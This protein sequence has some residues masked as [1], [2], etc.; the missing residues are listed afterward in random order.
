MDSFVDYMWYLLLSPWKR[1]KKAVN[2]WYIFCKVFGGMLD[3]GMMVL[4][5]ARDET[6][7][8]TCCDE[9]LDI[10]GMEHGLSRYSGEKED[11]FR[12][13]IAFDAEIRKTGG[14]LIGL[15]NVLAALNIKNAYIISAKDYTG[16]TERWAEFYVV[17]NMDADDEQQ[18]PLSILKRE[19]RK[20]KRVGSK[21]NYSFN[22]RLSVR[23]L[24]NIK[25]RV[26][27]HWKLF[28]WNY[29]KLNGNCILDGNKLLNTCRSTYK[30]KT[31]YTTSVKHE[32]KIH[33]VR[34]YK[35]HNIYYLDGSCANDGSKLL[36]AWEEESTV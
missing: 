20:V 15:K 26:I 5:R 17:I 12:R 35:Q 19:I 24:N 3:E 32:E 30:I 1:V 13:R 14:T 11:A 4:D 8:A 27:Y 36:D 6:M 16:D 21:D 22:Y 29:D 33:K 9:M 18:L 10:H 28:F 2:Q 34:V 23:Q 31:I 7:L 25:N